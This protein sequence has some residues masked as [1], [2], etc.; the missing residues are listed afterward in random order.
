MQAVPK[1]A[2]RVRQQPERAAKRQRTAAPQ[3]AAQQAEH[4]QPCAAA[5]AP[6][7]EPDAAEGGDLDEDIESVEASQGS[8]QA[9]S[10]FSLGRS[11]LPTSKSEGLDSPQS[12][13]ASTAKRRPAVSQQPA[14]GASAD[15]AGPAQPAKLKPG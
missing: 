4:A 11:G 6:P 10:T 13:P 3:P 7:A 12:R 9:G 1:Q 5:L 14:A 2:A 15:T 8:S